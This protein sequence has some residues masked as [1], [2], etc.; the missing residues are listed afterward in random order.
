MAYVMISSKNRATS[1]ASS[2]AIKRHYGTDVAK[3]LR[4]FAQKEIY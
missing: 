3:V 4:G 2:S 1:T